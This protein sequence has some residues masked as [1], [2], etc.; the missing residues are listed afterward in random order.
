MVVKNC[1]THITLYMYS[2]VDVRSIRLRLYIMCENVSLL[3]WTHIKFGFYHTVRMTCFMNIGLTDY[4]LELTT[5]IP[6]FD[7]TMQVMVRK[8]KKKMLT[9]EKM[10]Q[11]PFSP[12]TWKLWLVVLGQYIFCFL[13]IFSL[14]RHCNEEDF[15][16]SSLGGG[17]TE[18]LYKGILTAFGGGIVLTPKTTP[19]KIVMVGMSLSLLVF[20]S[21]YG[22]QVTTALVESRL[23]GSTGA[24]K[25]FDE[26]LERG[27]AFC[28]YASVV[29]IS[30]LYV[31]TSFELS[32]FLRKKRKIKSS[33]FGR[34]GPKTKEYTWIHIYWCMYI[35]VSICKY[36]WICTECVCVHMQVYVCI[37][38]YI[39]ICVWLSIFVWYIYIHI[40]GSLRP[41]PFPKDEYSPSWA[42]WEGVRTIRRTLRGQVRG[43]ADHWKLVL[44]SA[45]PG[46]LQHS[47][48]H[49]DQLK[50]G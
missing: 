1:K 10:M 9:V 22:A 39:Q 43:I 25:S 48:I 35:Y 21:I 6:L 17:I 12:F 4:R 46:S 26:G 27:A 42:R 8:Q 13:V 30:Y 14:E 37:Y 3:K 7:D 44:L 19:G 23:G 41:G 16:D 50:T 31:W 11:L 34:S 2:C 47:V 33:L 28:V 29:C 15:P 40:S 18:S 32:F 38:I 49:T 5:T 45:F 36:V 24:M 20:M